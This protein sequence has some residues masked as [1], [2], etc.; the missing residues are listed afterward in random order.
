MAEDPKPDTFKAKKKK[1]AASPDKMPSYSRSPT[2]GL[3]SVSSKVVLTTSP[4]KG[5]LKDL[6]NT[7]VTVNQVRPDS[8]T[9][10]PVKMGRA[11]DA[12]R[13]SKNERKM[14]R[15]SSQKPSEPVESKPPSLADMLTN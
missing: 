9:K 4:S 13:K 1:N 10:S 3:K 5:S 8:P 15:M 14:E 2:K 7:A 6:A 11:K 12:A